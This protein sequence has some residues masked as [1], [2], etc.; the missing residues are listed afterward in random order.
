MMLNPILQTACHLVMGFLGSGKTSFINACIQYIQQ[1]ERWAILVNEIGKIGIDEQLFT[2]NHRLAIRQVSGGCICCTSQLPLQVAISRLLSEHRPER[3]WIEP[4]GLAHP[5]ELIDQLSQTHWQT[6]LSLKTVYSVLNAKQWQQ[7]KYQ[8]HE[9]YQAHVKY[10]D[11][12]IINRFSDLTTIEIEQL[13]QWIYRLNPNVNIIWQNGN[14]FSQEQFKQIDSSLQVS[15]IFI[16]KNYNK[17]NLLHYLTSSYNV[18]EHLTHHDAELPF[19]YHQQHSNYQI[20][21]WQLPSNWQIDYL[22]LMDWLLLLPNWQRIKGVVHTSQGW[23][24]LNFTE[25]SLNTLNCEPQ[26]DNRIEIIFITEPE[27]LF[28]EKWDYSLMQLFS[29]N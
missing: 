13:T 12:L 21:G 29:K 16:Q 9:G 17:I 4:T 27:N 25:D 5:K 8:Q 26:I 18:S 23:Q 7:P 2:N 14:Y 20:I 15:S 11:V 3:L 1:Q 10:C 28:W 24:R 19:R 6:A 22:K